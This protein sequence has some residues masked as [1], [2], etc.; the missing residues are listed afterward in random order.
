MMQR[1]TSRR[2]K[3]LATFVLLTSSLAFALAE[4]ALMNG[5]RSPDGRYEVRI[6]RERS[7][8]P[9]SVPDGYSIYLQDTKAK[10]TRPTLRTVGG[11]LRY[12]G[13]TERCQAVWHSS[14]KFVAI[15]DQATRHSKELYLFAVSGDRVTRLDLPDYAQNALGRVGATEIDLHSISTPKAW[16]GDDLL[17]EFYFSTSQPERGRFFHSV[18]VVLRLSHGPNAVPAVRLKSVGNLKKLEG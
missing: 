18:D 12:A 13:A 8:G 7:P 3:A 2:L 16:D 6:A 1:R 5:G 11:Y 17:L 10:Q 14:G 15:C 4:D 9:A